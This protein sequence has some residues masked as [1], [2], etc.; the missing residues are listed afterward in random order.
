MA[1]MFISLHHNVTGE[2]PS[3]EKPSGIPFL[4]ESGYKDYFAIYFYTLICIIMH[5][6]LQEYVLDVSILYFW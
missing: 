5:A 4:Y 1:N 2:E 3:H 6:V